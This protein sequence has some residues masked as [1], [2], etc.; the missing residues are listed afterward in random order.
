VTVLIAVFLLMDTMHRSHTP[1]T[2]MREMWDVVTVLL[3]QNH[4][5]PSFTDA[6]VL[7]GDG[8]G[9]NVKEYDVCTSDCVVFRDRPLQFDP[10]RQHQLLSPSNTRCPVCNEARFH[11]H[12]QKGR[13]KFS[14]LGTT[15]QLSG[16]LW[17]KEWREAIR[18]VVPKVRH[19]R[20]R[21]HYLHAHTHALSLP[22]SLSLSLSLSL[23]PSR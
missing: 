12:S 22:L 8:T 20:A 19:P 15:N 5:L 17:F 23:A 21:A 1:V 2:K 16:R 9:L 7:V 10:T 4:L 14:W 13:K 11:P 6:L 18:L 3:P